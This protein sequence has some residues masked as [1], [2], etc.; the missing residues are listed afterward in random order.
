MDTL[1]DVPQGITPTNFSIP[2]FVE[3]EPDCALFLGDEPPRPLTNKEKAWVKAAEAT[4]K[5]RPE[6]LNKIRAEAPSAP[7]L[8]LLDRQMEKYDGPMPV[9]REQWQNYVLLK[10][11][12]QSQDVDPKISKPALDALAKTTVVGLHVEQKEISITTRSTV[13]LET[14]LMAKLSQILGKTK[15]EEVIEGEWTE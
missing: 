2:L 8:K 14:E 13:E 4:A 9:T 6:S 12:E 11:F 5:E 10:Y 3:G 15:R 1:D 7:A